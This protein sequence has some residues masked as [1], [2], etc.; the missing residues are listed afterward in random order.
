MKAPAIFR[1]L[2]VGIHHPTV[3]MVRPKTVAPLSLVV[4]FMHRILPQLCIIN[5][6]GSEMRLMSWFSPPLLG[7]IVSSSSNKV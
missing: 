5:Q 7:S 2:L 6:C 1:Q 4:K 3:Q